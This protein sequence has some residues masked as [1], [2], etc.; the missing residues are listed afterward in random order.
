MTPKEK[1]ILTQ[2]KLDLMDTEDRIMYIDT[3]A[4]NEVRDK[5]EEVYK[6]LSQYHI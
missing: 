4:C 1:D 5:I 2:V 3:P 6:V